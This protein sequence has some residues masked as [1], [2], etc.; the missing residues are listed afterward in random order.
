MKQKIRK[1]N[2]ETSYFENDE[3]MERSIG[4]LFQFNLK[5]NPS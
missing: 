1:N 5:S 4:K 2:S 3:G